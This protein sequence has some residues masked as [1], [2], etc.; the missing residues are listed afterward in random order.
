[1]SCRNPYYFVR[2]RVNAALQT[3]LILVIGIVGVGFLVKTVFRA[4][5]ERGFR[6]LK[7]WKEVDEKRER[8]ARKVRER[9]A[10]IEEE[11]SLKILAAAEKAEA[12]VEALLEEK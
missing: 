7:N 9:M 4:Q 1:M 8:D 3:L 5:F 11:E 12:E 10:K 6:Y 2:I